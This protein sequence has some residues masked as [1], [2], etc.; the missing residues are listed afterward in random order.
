[1]LV[2]LRDAILCFGVRQKAALAMRR[3]LQQHA[4][5]PAKSYYTCH[6]GDRDLVHCHLSFHFP[7]WQEGTQFPGPI[8]SNP[9]TC[10]NAAA[11]PS[12]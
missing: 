6:T 10:S 12:S 8:G 2:L 9:A 7:G 1:M 3:R 4:T 5:C 11:G